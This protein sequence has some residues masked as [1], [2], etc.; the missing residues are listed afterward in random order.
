MISGLVLGNTK[1][2]KPLFW[3]NMENPHAAVTGRSGSGKSY[4]VKR[5]VVQAVQQGALVLVLDYSGDFCGYDP[6]EDLPFQCVDVL[7]PEFRVNPLVGAP[8]ADA[9]AQQLLSLLHSVFRMGVRSMAA[10]LKTAR[11]YLALDSTPTLAG[12]RTYATMIQDS[13]RGLVAALEPVE[14]LESLLHPGSEA[15]S[16]NLSE[17][18]LTVL[19]LTGLLD[20]NMVKIVVELILRCV[21]NQRTASATP[22]ILVMDECQSI[23]WGQS[24]M[25]IRILREGR[26]FNVAGWFSTQWLTNK[27]ATA[28]IGQAALQ[29]YFRPDDQNVNQ[30]AK[31]LCQGG[32]G[33][34]CQYQRLVSSLRRGQ[35]LWQRSDGRTVIVNV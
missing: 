32:S 29:A 7:S 24:S 35:F 28:A 25:A 11:D 31:K 14:L 21:W 17:P 4:F 15:I 18:G 8:T 20:P 30:L 33:N 13:G 3:E 12:L 23:S 26:K 22:L 6:P 10:L 5:M 1:S 27:E 2:G 34:I 19:D 16:L 9:C